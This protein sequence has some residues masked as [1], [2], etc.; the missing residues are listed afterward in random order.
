MRGLFDNSSIH[1][2]FL[3]NRQSD[4]SKPLGCLGYQTKRAHDWTL[5]GFDIISHLAFCRESQT[6]GWWRP[7]ASTLLSLLL[8]L[9]NNLCILSESVL[10]HLRCIVVEQAESSTRAYIAYISMPSVIAVAIQS[11]WAAALSEEVQKAAI[12]CTRQLFALFGPVT[13]D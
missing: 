7:E 6:L 9:L 12:F 1:I 2:L 13:L 10:T 3:T 11:R 4:P 8:F 5:R